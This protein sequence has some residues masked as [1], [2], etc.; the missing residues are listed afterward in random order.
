M[1]AEDAFCREAACEIG[2]AQH[3]TAS[4]VD[5]WFVL[6]Y[7]GPWAAK[8][9]EKASVGDAARQHVDAWVKRT[10]GARIQLARRNRDDV[11]RTDSGGAALMLAST[12]QASM[13]GVGPTLARFDLPAVDALVDLD[14]DAAIADLRAGRLPAGARA[15]DRPIALVCTNGKRDRCCAKW[16]LPLFDA[17]A[18]DAR[19]EAW[20]TT[21]IG[22]H[23]F[24]A[25]MVW[26]PDGVCYGRVMPGDVGRLTDAVVR[27][28]IGP[29]ELVR[30]RTS[31]PEAAQAA[32]VL[33]RRELGLQ[34]HDDLVITGCEREAGSDTRW[35]VRGTTN[36][37]PVE[38]TVERHTGLSVAPPSC[39][40]P[41]EP[42]THWALA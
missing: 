42:S 18:Q 9:W 12:R 25:T 22:G 10:A 38:R 32:E 41:A 1:D 5:A 31:L 40:K 6:E 7:T 30:G 16:G 2:V 8:A 36:G 27:G 37:R 19:I 26:L 4:I 34:R 13:G 29:L 14:L 17:L 33:C 39:G 23:R 15:V 11:E 20:Q 3:G 24:A 21:H 28:E 35:L